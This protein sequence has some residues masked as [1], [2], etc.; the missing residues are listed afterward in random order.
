MSVGALTRESKASMVFS[1]SRSYGFPIR[2]ETES[3]L[4]H[5]RFVFEDARG[6]RPRRRRKR[7]AG[8]A[9]RRKEV[10]ERRKETRLR[11]EPVGC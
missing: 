11:G 1:S 9:A 4:T 2:E 10:L 5:P 7:D 6:S 3:Y 8:R